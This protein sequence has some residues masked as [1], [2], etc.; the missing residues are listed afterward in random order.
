MTIRTKTGEL[1]EVTYVR[2]LRTLTPGRTNIDVDLYRLAS[3][4]LV[5]ASS[6]ANDGRITPCECGTPEEYGYHAA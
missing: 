1:T 2:H 5:A 4:S 6:P 3:G